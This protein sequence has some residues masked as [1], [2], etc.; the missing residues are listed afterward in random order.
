MLSE[1][2]VIDKLFESADK[3]NEMYQQKKYPQ[4]MYQ[5]DL[6]SMVAVFMEIDHETMRLLFGQGNEDN[7]FEG[8]FNRNK[9]QEAWLS[10]IKQ[11]RERPYITAAELSEMK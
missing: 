1:T 11:G 9:V 6:A 10:C 5:Y 3:F 8:Y 7:D 2:E 4:A